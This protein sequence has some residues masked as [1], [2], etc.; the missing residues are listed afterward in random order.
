MLP[1]ITKCLNL[2]AIQMMPMENMEAR[3]VA[4]ALLMLKARYGEIKLIARDSGTNLLEG[5]LNP[6][7]DSP[8]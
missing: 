3:Q 1:L 4:L 7:V 6:Q 5:N 2:S 8:V